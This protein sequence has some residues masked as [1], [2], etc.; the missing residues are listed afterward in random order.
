LYNNFY[1]NP[2]AS[3]VANLTFD[4][5]TNIF[6]QDAEFFI[7]KLQY[8]GRSNNLLAIVEARD[9]YQTNPSGVRGGQSG[10]K[11]GLSPRTAIFPRQ[12]D[13]TL[14]PYSPFFHLPTTL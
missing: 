2:V 7:K 9:S 14:A 12:N 11:V 3:R 13:C 4:I 10:T 1:A 8:Q 6:I 5:S